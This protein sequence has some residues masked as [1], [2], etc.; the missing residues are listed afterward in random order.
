MQDQALPP[1]VPVSV[2][3]SDQGFDEVNPLVNTNASLPPSPLV[4]AARVWKA[5]ASVANPRLHLEV[6]AGWAGLS[7][8]GL[9]GGHALLLSTGAA[10]NI[11]PNLNPNPYSSRC[12]GVWGS[13]R[14]SGWTRA[15]A[16]APAWRGTSVSCAPSTA[17]AAS[18]PSFPPPQ[19]RCRKVTAAGVQALR[20]TTAAPNLHIESY[21]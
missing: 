13:G 17:L 2:V 18:Q 20:N 5:A 9:W 21:V 8:R 6:S 7:S 12:C 10:G 3:S 14:W 15:C 19:I 4:H 1:S 16:R 11:N